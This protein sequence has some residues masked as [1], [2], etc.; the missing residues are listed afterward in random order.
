MSK[1]SL[2]DVKKV[3]KLA[4]LPISSQEEQVYLGQIDKIIGYIDN[5]SP[6]DTFKI[7]PTFSVAENVNNFRE[8]KDKESLDPQEALKNTNSQEKGL[9]VIKGV[10][11][12]E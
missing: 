11:G 5:L 4:Y 1:I 12:D 7:D 2:E 3:A 6:L 10:F 8:D 9:F